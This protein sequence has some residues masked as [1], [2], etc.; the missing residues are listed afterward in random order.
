MVGAVGQ[1]LAPAPV[2]QAGKQTVI[3]PAGGKLGK[4]RG[5][6]SGEKRLV[7]TVRLP[8]LRDCG[9][10]PDGLMVNKAVPQVL[11]VGLQ[12]GGPPLPGCLD[13]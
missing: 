7:Q 6:F 2:G 10:Q 9:G 11:D 4:M 12:I 13:S 3:V 8:T 5:D 1:L